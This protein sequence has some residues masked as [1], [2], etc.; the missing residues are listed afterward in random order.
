MK[1]ISVG[2]SRHVS[3]ITAD[4]QV[5]RWNDGEWIPVPRALAD[6]SAAGDGTVWGITRNGIVVQLEEE[7]VG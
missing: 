6:I 1:H 2:D 7:F 4:N 3:G 5:V